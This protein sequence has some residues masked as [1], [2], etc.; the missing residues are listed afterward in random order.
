VTGAVRR[1][2]PRLEG[3]RIAVGLS[4]GVDSVVLLHSLSRH[5]PLRA[6]HVHHGL[7]RNA[8]EW[9]RFCRRLC[10][11]LGVPLTV[12]RV[13]VEKRGKGVEAAAREARYRVF[14]SLSVD[15]VALAHQLDDQAET[16][17]MSLL[18][19]AGPR[20]ASGMPVERPLDGK[21]LLRPLLDVP[22]EAIVDYARRHGLD[23]VEDE[24]NDS[25]ALMRNFV[26]RRIGPLLA[27]RYPRWRE[28]L[29]RAAQ[30][31]ARAEVD[32]ERLLRAFLQERGLRAPSAAKL[33]EM[34]KQLAA[35][36]SGTAIE[37][38]GARLRLY[39]GKLIGES[40][41]RAE[42]FVPV[43]WRGER[44]LPIPALGGV[45]VFRRVRG[46]GIDPRALEQASMVVRLR[47][48]GER[49]QPSAARPR[50]TL[51]NLFQEAGVPAWERSRLPLVYN[52]D[53]LV[54]VPGIGVDVRYQTAKNRAGFVAEWR[55]S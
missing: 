8:D 25:E 17:L 52:G 50:R 28:A 30:H 27:E 45:L 5:L 4:G 32:A 10:R 42:T 53:A 18:R 3:K 35:G 15:V 46:R 9:T 1:S 26:R 49:L 29:A 6:V 48:G 24:S 19:G 11:T 14:R 43:A 2:L 39:R 40:I 13:R 22:R 36:R 41:T 51:K 44:R 47:A 34:V 7:S 54:C 31:F 12:R 23:W 55:N 16:V 20:G 33:S 37:H 38:D 21:L